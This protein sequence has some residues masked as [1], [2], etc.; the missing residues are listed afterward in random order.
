MID[1]MSAVGVQTAC[2]QHSSSTG[3]TYGQ[4]QL[5]GSHQS[6]TPSGSGSS[7]SISGAGSASASGVY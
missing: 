2:A 6:S 5:T 1:L 4:N 3:I 7:G